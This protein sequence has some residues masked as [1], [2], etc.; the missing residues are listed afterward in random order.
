MLPPRV[1]VVSN[2]TLNRLLIRELDERELPFRMGMVYTT[3][4]RNWEFNQRAAMAEI[5]LG[6][7]IAVDME[8]ATVAANGFRYRV[9]SSTLLV[10][11]DKP[12][13][14]QPKLEGPAKDFY[15]SSKQRHLEVALAAVDRVRSEFS[16][17]LPT[18]DLRSTDEPLI[19]SASDVDSPADLMD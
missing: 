16:A 15:Q 13:H 2:F 3:D 10:V 18:S 9:P 4:N 8:S 1:P 6:R 12:L 14:G 7:A 11:S 19:G 17:G 5:Q